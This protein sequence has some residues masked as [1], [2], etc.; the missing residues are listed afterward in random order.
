LQRLVFIDSNNNHET[1][2]KDPTELTRKLNYYSKNS[3]NYNDIHCF[4]GENW[5]EPYLSR[6]HVNNRLL[7]Q[8]TGS[9]IIR[10]SRTCRNCFALSIRV[11]YFANSTGIAHYLIIKNRNGFKLKGVDKEFKTLKALVTHYS[12]MQEILPVTLKVYHKNI[13]NNN[14]FID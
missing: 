12:V 5:F 14:C 6:E 4:N 9:F 10:L 2:F 11:P 13:N 7:C 8:E 3:N 1:T